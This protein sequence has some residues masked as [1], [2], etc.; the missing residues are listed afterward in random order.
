[1]NLIRIEMKRLKI[2][3][4][5]GVHEEELKA[6]AEFEVRMDI[7]FKANQT[8]QELNQT[9][10]YTTVYNIIR[11]EMAQARPLL[12]TVGAEIVNRVRLAYPYVEEI[13][14]TIS[15]IHPPLANFRGELGVTVTNR[16]EL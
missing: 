7:L 5:H 15:K 16:I 12:E 13:N 6:G 9:V 8:I 1:M 4:H 2:F 14:I 11:E 3:A 10:D